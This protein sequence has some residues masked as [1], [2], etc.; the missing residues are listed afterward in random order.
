MGEHAKRRIDRIGGPP[1]LCHAFEMIDDV[2]R[3]LN[4]GPVRQ[5]DDGYDRAP[6]GRH[7]AFGKARVGRRHLVIGDALLAQIGACLGGVEGMRE[8]V[9]PDNVFI[10][11]PVLTRRR[12]KDNLAA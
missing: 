6:D 5:F 4:D 12:A 11:P 9:E 7:D 3:V 1:H 8:A 2:D 10:H